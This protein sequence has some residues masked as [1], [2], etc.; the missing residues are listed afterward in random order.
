[1]KPLKLFITKSNNIT[2]DSYVWNTLSATMFA[3]QS[4]I[5]LIIITRT[6]G[7]DDAGIFSM[8]YAVGSLIYYLGEYGVRKYQVSDVREELSFSDYHSHRVVVCVMALVASMV[9]VVYCQKTKGYSS[10]KAYI[11]LMI[12]LI[13]IVEAYSE[14]FFAR[15]QQVGRL[16]VSAK[17]NLYRTCLGMLAFMISLLITRNMTVS[18]TVWF[19][20]V[21]LAF[22]SSN[23]PVMNEFAELKFV[24]RWSKIWKVFKD[25]FPMFIGYFLMLYISNAPKYAID[26]CMTETDQACYNFIFMPVFAIGLFAN[27]IFNPIL[28]DLTHK[29]EDAEYKSFHR[30]VIRQ[31]LVIAAITLLAIAVALTIGCPVLGIMYNADLSEFKLDLAILMIGGGMLALV[32]FFS[33]ILTVVRYQNY[34][35]WGYVSVAVLAGFMSTRMVRDHGIDGAAVLYTVLTAVLAAIFAVMVVLFTKEKRADNEPALPND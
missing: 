32:N 26:A 1:M 17:T 11:V 23:L 22:L 13:K 10:Y 27:F 18:V 31:T 2:R 8:A 7:L 24:F 14:V 19:V 35:T 16:D 21:V 30:I 33:V 9:Y 25:C 3:L 29:W 34:L 5:V 4:A 12:C 15:Y 20:V 6:N 28:V